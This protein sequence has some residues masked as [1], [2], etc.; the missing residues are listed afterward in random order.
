MSD[1]D[2]LYVAMV[3]LAMRNELMTDYGGY[4]RGRNRLV[5]SV[6]H[7]LA[8]GVVICGRPMA[9]NDVALAIH[10]MKTPDDQN[11]N[12][13]TT[14][15]VEVTALRWFGMHV[16]IRRLWDDADWVG[17]APRWFEVNAPMTRAETVM[18]SRFVAIV[19]TEMR[20]LA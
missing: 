16:G 3:S 11:A 6:A 2:D 7:E 10:A 4:R 17:L 5:E 14:Q 9:T 20:R 12:E 19:R 15:R 13:L 18:V 1:F 8:H